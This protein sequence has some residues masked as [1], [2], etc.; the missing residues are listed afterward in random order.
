MHA[1]AID[2]TA[3]RIGRTLLVLALPLDRCQCQE[4]GT[5]APVVLDVLL[6][7]GYKRAALDIQFKP[8]Y[9]TGRLV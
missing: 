7:A 2:M 4:M 3:A 9:P 8:V 1:P 6:S 5:L